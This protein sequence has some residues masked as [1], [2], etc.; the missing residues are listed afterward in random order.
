[1]CKPHL[2]GLKEKGDVSG[3]QR[4]D[5]GFMLAIS[6]GLGLRKMSLFALLFYVKCDSWL[7]VNLNL[8]LQSRWFG[9]GG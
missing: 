1:M 4:E 5:S 9:L 2:G 6:L 7:V 8:R 3:A